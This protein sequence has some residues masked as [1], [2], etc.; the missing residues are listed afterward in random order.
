VAL[1]RTDVSDELI[2]SIIGS[3]DNGGDEFL[4]FLQEPHG[5]TSHKTAFF[6]L[7]YSFNASVTVGNQ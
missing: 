5:V 3:S 6:N 2:A 7:N 1:A 4:R